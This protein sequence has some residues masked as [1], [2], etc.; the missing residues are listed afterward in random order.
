MKKWIM[1]VMAVG[2]LH[3]GTLLAQDDALGLYFSDSTFSAETAST[4]VTPGFMMAGYIVL[5]NPTGVLI[6]GYE[7]GITCT[8]GDFAIPLTSLFFDLNAGTT[9]NQIVTFLSPKPVV[10]GGTVLSTIFFTTNSL[11]LETIA[12]GASSPSSLPGDLPVIDYGAGGLV[13]CGRPFGTPVVAWLNGQAV[14]TEGSSWG[15]V[16]ATFR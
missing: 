7:V 2:L 6:D 8:A 10:A 13:A 12:F 11:A 5:T 1:V 4:T 15:A 9:A 14:A 3:A 16:K